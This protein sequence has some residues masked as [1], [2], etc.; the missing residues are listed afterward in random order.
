VGSAQ[1]LPQFPDHLWVTEFR[2]SSQD[3]D[4]A[5]GSPGRSRRA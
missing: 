4:V 3:R 5:H 2:E 1:P